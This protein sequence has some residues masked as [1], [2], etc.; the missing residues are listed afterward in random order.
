MP[1]IADERDASFIAR[2]RLSGRVGPR[3]SAFRSGA[4]WALR[5]CGV[6]FAGS[7]ILACGEGT[8]TDADPSELVSSP[9]SAAIRGIAVSEDDNGCFI[10]ADGNVRCWA[11]PYAESLGPAPTTWPG[12]PQNPFAPHLV[13][14]PKPATMIAAGAWSACAL[15]SDSTVWCWGDNSFGQLGWRGPQAGSQK[16]VRIIFP[17]TRQIPYE[18]P[19]L[20]T[21]V[22]GKAFSYCVTTPSAGALCWGDNSCGELGIGTTTGS[23]APVPPV[24][25]G[26]GAGVTAIST[27]FLDA[28]AIVSNE[29]SGSR[30][31]CWGNNLLGQLGDLS[32]TFSATPVAVW[33]GA[34]TSPIGISVSDEG[35]CALD[36]SGAV[37]CWGDDVFGELGNGVADDLLY[38]WPQRVHNPTASPSAVITGADYACELIGST[39][40]CWGDNLWGQLTVSPSTVWHTTP[41]RLPTG[42]LAAGAGPVA[43]LAAGIGTT[44]WGTESGHVVC[45]GGGQQGSPSGAYSQVW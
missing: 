28:C 14:L 9:L 42:G 17:A 8:P 11:G 20:A 43:H 18:S 38:S 16:P 34:L 13:P 45:L 12:D 35:A 15:L 27:S 31:W 24:G 22:S 40:Y 7:W 1:T 33:N 36:A 2:T 26:S 39:P 19:V 37:Y 21:S 41:T 4:V 3:G 6:L 25:L 29:K 10:D 5:V 23:A 44:C 32:T 30:A